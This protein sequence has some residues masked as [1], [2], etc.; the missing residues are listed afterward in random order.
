MLPPNLRDFYPPIE[1]YET[2]RL[3]VDEMHTL[4]WEQCGN[5]KGKPILFVQGGPGASIAPIHRQFFDPAVWR[6]ILFDQRGCGQS[7]PAGELR[8]NTTEHLISDIE[9]LREHLGLKK[10]HLFGGSWGST[11]S[12]AYGEEHP[13]RCLGFVLRGVFLFRQKEVEWYANGI[14]TIR[15]EAWEKYASLVPVEE[16]GDLLAAYLRRLKD[17]DPETARRAAKSMIAYEIS[18]ATISPASE[19]ILSEEE[20]KQYALMPLMEA[21]YMTNNRPIPDDK[22]LANVTRLHGIPATIVQGRYD[23]I[24]PALSA[25]ELH[26]NWPG[27]ELIIIENGGHSSFDPGVRSA[28]I[29]ATDQMANK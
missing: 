16:R 15:P 23:L 10:W 24:C 5:P 7:T 13:E 22:Y 21:H 1:P 29:E 11:L 17:P 4:Y 25:Y 28:L 12:L 3:P 18:S 19:F 8:N 6:I 9:K 14:R 2:G 27:S 26:K 20:E